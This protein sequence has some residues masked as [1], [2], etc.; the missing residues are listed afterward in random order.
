MGPRLRGD[1]NGSDL[2]GCYPTPIMS[3]PFPHCEALVRE[4]DKDRFLAT[5]F[6][7]AKHRRPL[8]A[9]YAFNV[10]VARVREQAREP[11]PGEIRLQWW[12][13]VFGGS[14][15]GEVR[16]NPV[17]AALLDTVV[18]YRL[19]PRVFNDLIDARAFDLYDDPMGTLDEL[20][21]YVRK[22]SAAV[23]A[24]AARILNDGNDPRSDELVAHA[25]AAYGIAGL[26][27]SF[28]NHVLHR[29]LFV[30]LDV[31]HRRGVQP[32]SVFVGKDTPELRSAL[33]DLGAHAR[34]HLTAAK[35]LI[36]DAP[37]ELLPALLPVAL[38]RPTLVRLER[39]RRNPFK[40]M[41]LPQWRRQWILWRAARSGLAGAL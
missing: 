8:F 37:A 7:P 22:T 13:D 4:A 41:L 12:R 19:P 20:D 34:S 16:A 21:G 3:D 30:P 23:M 32:E 26:M 28:P 33:A 15:R 2:I 14:G 5:L 38:V 24:L 35:A 1:D 9:L 6:A 18:R 10:E 29:Q 36:G 40:P 27:A 11:M 39:R 25:G 17:A 31:L